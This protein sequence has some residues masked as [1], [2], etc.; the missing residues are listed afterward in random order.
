MTY[1]H[2]A[3]GA[4]GRIIAVCVEDRIEAGRAMRALIGADRLVEGDEREIESSRG[5]N[6]SAARCKR[7]LRRSDGAAGGDTVGVVGKTGACQRVCVARD[8][9]DRREVR[10]V[11]RAKAR[12]SAC[13]IGILGALVE[14][15]GRQNS[16]CDG[17][18][19]IPFLCG[20][21][22]IWI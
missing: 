2:V 1:Q 4:A 6:D 7:G 17:R 22:S 8:R 3:A 11:M 9:V 5:Q 15:V 20:I 12:I 16:Y 14:T 10:S 21:A 13:P 18:H 19:D